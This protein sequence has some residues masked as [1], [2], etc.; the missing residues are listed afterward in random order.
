MA[1]IFPSFLTKMPHIHKSKSRN[2]S[3]NSSQ[4]STASSQG[5]PTVAKVEDDD[6]GTILAKIK[7]PQSR[8]STPKN[9]NRGSDVRADFMEPLTVSPPTPPPLPPS[10]WDTLGMTEEEFNAMQ[11]RVHRQYLQDMRQT[12]I[13]NLLSELDSPGYWT[14]RIERLEKEREVFNKKRGW[15]AMDIACVEQIDA[16]IKECEDELERIHSEVDR[17]EYEYD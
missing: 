1:G 11:E 3:R 10:P 2:N 6:F 8:K 4:K 7:P 13:D 15:S 5:K 9:T 14:R 16:D 12:Y 17:L